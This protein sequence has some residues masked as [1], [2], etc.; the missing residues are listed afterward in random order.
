M[1]FIMSDEPKV[2]RSAFTKHDEPGTTVA[3][4]VLA[5]ELTA[6]TDQKTRKAKT[7]ANGRTLKQL[8][9]VILTGW[10]TDPD[11]DG[12]RKLFV[13]GNLRSA[14]KKAIVAAGDNDLRNGSRL[15]VTYTGLGAA[16]NPDY[17]APRL[18]RAKYEPPTEDSIAELAAFLEELTA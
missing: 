13:K 10:Q 18:Y 6:Q 4:L 9:V 3:G 1:S 7:T 5:Q 15:T 17:S 11:D 12:R 16:A 2:I 8:E 14:I